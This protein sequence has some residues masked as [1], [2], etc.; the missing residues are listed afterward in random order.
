MTG[1]VVDLKTGKALKP[2]RPMCEDRK[3]NGEPCSNKA[4]RGSTKCGAHAGKTGRPKAL[5]AAKKEALLEALGAGVTLQDAATFAKLSPSTLHGYLADA[6]KAAEEGTESEFSELMEEIT[7]AM[8]GVK[9]LVSG[10][11]I[12][13]VTRGNV[14]AMIAY[15]ERR[16]PQE[17]SKTETHEH[18]HTHGGVLG[19]VELLGGQQPMHV[20]W[21]KREQIAAILAEEDVIEG[22]VAS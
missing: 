17:W 3:R 15:L 12:K 19:V 11:L 8:I 18:S 13:A 22:E 2:E 6:R 1:K 20:P 9:V 4:K 14:P 21:R 10:H 5:D 16:H 7:A